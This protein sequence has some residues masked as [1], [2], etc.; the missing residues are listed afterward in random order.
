MFKTNGEQP[1]DP[2]ER[3]HGRRMAVEGSAIRSQ[4]VDAA[5]AVLAEH[6]AGALSA[7]KVA[8]QAG[9]K[10][11]LLYYYFRTMDDLVLAVV[12][13][14]N[15]RRLTRFVDALTSPEPLRALWEQM[16]DPGSAR[17][18]AQLTTIANDRPSI[19]AGIVSSAR[20]FRALQTEAVRRLLP[21][22]SPSAEGIVMI[23][24]SLARTMVN[25]SALGLT[26]G[27]A[28]ARAIV[29]QVLGGLKVA[30]E[31]VRAEAR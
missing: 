25:E 31:P 9:L 14:V 2:A 3:G 22:G 27:H 18:A 15:D 19:S 24:A 16:A 30:G 21:P 20:Q 23:A 8:A 29:E 10:P 17:L 13:R 28:E 6:G 5:E 1:G 7:G 12:E 26:E 4:F 11:Q